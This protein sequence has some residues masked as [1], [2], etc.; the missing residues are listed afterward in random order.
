MEDK[1]FLTAKEVARLFEVSANTVARWAREGRVP[2]LVTP[3]GRRK[4]PREEIERLV[5]S[6]VAPLLLVRPERHVYQ[7]TQ[8][9]GD[10]T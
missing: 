10:R 9:G 3:S 4:F 1:R 6:G 5:G 2:A 7:T 8:K